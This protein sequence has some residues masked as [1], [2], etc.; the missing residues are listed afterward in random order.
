[1]KINVSVIIC[2]YNSE[3]RIIKTLEYLKLQKTN[4]LFE[5]IVVNNNCTDNSITKAL[6]YWNLTQSINPLIILEEKNQGLSFARKTGVLEASGEVIIFCDDDNSFCCNYLDYC[7]NYLT[8]NMNIGAMCS[9]IIP[10]SNI[11]L[12]IWFSTYQRYYACGVFSLNSGD[13]TDNGWI[14]G[15]GLA[16]RRSV[17][18]GLYASGFNNLANG[19]NKKVLSSGE[20]VELCKWIILCGY[21]LWYDE[22]I[23]LIHNIPDERLTKEYVVKL[24]SDNKSKKLNYS[25]DLIIAIR[26][27]RFIETLFRFLLYTYKNGITRSSLDNLGIFISALLFKIG[28]KRNDFYNNIIIYSNYYASNFFKK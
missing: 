24:N 7:Y 27:N 28:I 19:R 12:P 18:S 11:K 17:I 15:A 16:M 26:N 3:Y 8:N 2:T 21:K 13:V 22:N 14:W 20:D 23:Y 1:M 4:L 9:S 5:V 6:D 25:Y 10:K